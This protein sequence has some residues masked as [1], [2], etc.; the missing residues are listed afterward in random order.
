MTTRIV[1]EVTTIKTFATQKKARATFEYL[2]SMGLTCAMQ[3]KSIETTPD[4]EKR[5]QEKE[6]L[7]KLLNS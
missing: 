2:G 3:S 6:Q 1:W 7:E 4:G 5:W